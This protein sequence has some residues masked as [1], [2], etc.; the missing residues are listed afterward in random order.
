MTDASAKIFVSRAF[1]VFA[2]TIVV[3][4]FSIRF[5]QLSSAPVWMDEAFTYLVSRLPLSDILFDRIDN[6][7]PL[8]Y[9]IQHLWTS[10]A[11]SVTFL[12]V[13]SAVAG[14]L[15]VAVAIFAGADLISKRAGLIA[16][17]LIALSTGHIYFSQDARMYSWLGLGVA[18]ASWG[19]AGRFDRGH[20]GPRIYGAL[21]VAGGALAVNVHITGLVYLAALNGATIAVELLGP[22]RAAF[23]RWWLIVNVILFV[24]SIPWL[25]AIPEASGSFP[26]LGANPS[27]LTHYFLRNAIGFAGLPK[28]LKVPMDGVLISICL[29]GIAILWLEGRR[30]AAAAGL[31]GLV[32]Y[33][34]LMALINLHTPLLANRIFMPS[35]V[36]AALLAGAALAAI[37][38][39][40]IGNACA[41]ALAAFMAWS[42]VSEHYSRTKYE[43]VPLAL[44][45]ADAAGYKSA[46]VI[47]CN[48]FTAG[49][50]F[51]YDPGRTNYFI[52]SRRMMRFDAGFPRA[53]TMSMAR[54]R[55]SSD[56]QIDAYLGGG[57]LVHDPETALRNIGKIVAITDPCD[58]EF[59]DETRQYLKGFGFRLMGEPEIP[60]P[61]HVVMENQATKLE[62]YARPSAG[63]LP[64]TQ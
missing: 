45:I 31:T 55:S 33:P 34:A 50:V 8:S 21:Y 39:P 22:R 30:G 23:L 11:P 61:D 53:F 63:D 12:R 13:P 41:A 44:T 18:I 29:G 47:S 28:I 1:A 26:G 48:Y 46:A 14:G 38:R 56:E 57:Y 7:P 25:L 60:K 40:A 49:S 2:S 54:V 58:P 51:A 62:L 20:F 43:N 9:A 52:R 10:V 64:L 4:G 5:W 27:Y 15:T 32:T 35:A 36:L 37:P 24:L 16:G 19:L 6:H 59:A 17:L 42:S 3:L